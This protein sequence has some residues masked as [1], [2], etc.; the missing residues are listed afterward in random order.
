VKPLP[1]TDQAVVLRTDGSSRAAWDSIC[2]IIRQP[3]GDFRAH[4]EFLDDP[5]YRDLTRD[6]LFALVPPNYGH[7]LL[8]VVDRDA[9]S[10]PEYPLLVLDLREGSNLEFRS[11]PSQI[12]GIENNLSIANMDFQEFADSVDRDG[13]FRGF[14]G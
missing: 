1:I 6:Q 11:I 5:E 13:V 14:G 9:V 7:T 3:V 12:Q 8:I 10:R 2:A 4:V